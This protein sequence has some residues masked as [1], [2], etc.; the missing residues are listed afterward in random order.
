M[1]MIGTIGKRMRRMQ[2]RRRR[3]MRRRKLRRGR[4]RLRS[5][6]RGRRNGRGRWEVRKEGGGGKIRKRSRNVGK[7]WDC[8]G[9]WGNSE[10]VTLQK[11]PITISILSF[12]RSH[13]V[14]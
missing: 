6:R 5:Q 13:A 2:R 9:Q 3:M 7:I 1:W 12:G 4:R 14:C 11:R 8:P 10:S